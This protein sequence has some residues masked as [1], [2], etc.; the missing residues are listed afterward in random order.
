MD[1]AELHRE[2]KKNQTAA[3][4]KSQQLSPCFYLASRG[5]AALRDWPVV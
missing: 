5:I 1:T 3:G 4:Q 2:L